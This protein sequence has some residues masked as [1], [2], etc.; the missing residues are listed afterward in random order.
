MQSNGDMGNETDL[1]TIVR[2]SALEILQLQSQLSL[3]E[4]KQQHFNTTA[5]VV[6]EYQ[7]ITNEDDKEDDLEK[8]YMV[9]ASISK[10]TDGSDSGSTRGSSSVGGSG[11]SNDHEDDNEDDLEKSYMVLASINKKTDGIGSGS[12]RGSSSVGGGG[13]IGDH[14]ELSVDGEA[15]Y[16]DLQEVEQMELL[17]VAEND[18]YQKRENV[19][20]APEYE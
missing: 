1:K 16:D 6:E 11:C 19:S 14:D 15:T 7:T 20:P 10:K 5:D 17:R 4:T 8:S 2:E 13:C 18:L 9:L 12:A 3:P